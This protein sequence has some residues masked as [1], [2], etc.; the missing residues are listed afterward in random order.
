M[1]RHGKVKANL[2][3]DPFMGLCCEDSVAKGWHVD[4]SAGIVKLCCTS[5]SSPKKFV[6]SPGDTGI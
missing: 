5:L 6:C 2:A 4:L 1:L 3:I